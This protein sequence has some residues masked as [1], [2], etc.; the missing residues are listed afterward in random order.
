MNEAPLLVSPPQGPA[1]I[2]GFV[3]LGENWAW[4][5]LFPASPEGMSAPPTPPHEGAEVSP[6]GPRGVGGGEGLGQSW[7]WLGSHISLIPGFKRRK[8]T[9]LQIKS[10]FSLI[11]FIRVDG[12]INS[13]FL[14]SFVLF[15]KQ[16]GTQGSEECYLLSPSELS[17]VSEVAEGQ[18]LNSQI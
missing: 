14:Y 17:T 13:S 9:Y 11:S 18:T 8:P 15:F 4:I 2:S 16:F 12:N 5:A 10:T 6:A 3:R 1:L 7:P